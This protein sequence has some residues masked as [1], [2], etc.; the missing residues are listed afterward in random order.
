M[1]R[2]V[3]DIVLLIFVGFSISVVYFSNITAVRYL[4]PISI[5]SLAWVIKDFM[6]VLKKKLK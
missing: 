2:I 4:L 3:L 6:E 1:K 5:L